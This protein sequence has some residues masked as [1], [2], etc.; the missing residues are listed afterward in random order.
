SEVIAIL[1]VLGLILAFVT[2]VG[3]GIWL[4]LAYLFRRQQPA[5]SAAKPVESDAC[6]RCLTAFRFGDATCPVCDW[7]QALPLGER[8]LSAVLAMRRQLYL[9]RQLGLVG[10][11][12]FRRLVGSLDTAATPVNAAIAE[13]VNDAVET[14]L[15]EAL[16][17][18]AGEAAQRAESPVAEAEVL[19]AEL[20]DAESTESIRESREAANLPSDSAVH[21]ASSVRY[22]SSPRPA[23][24]KLL[25][26]FLE[27]KNIR[28]GELVGGMLIVCCSIALVI[29]FWS[30]I[31]ERPLLKFCVF[32]GVSAAIFA[33]GLYTDRRWKLHTTSRGLL[34][35]AILLAP[36]NFLAIAAFTA[37]S[38]P[39]DVLSLAGEGASLVLF[40]ALCYLAAR[41]LVSDGKWLLAAGVMWPSLMQLLT[42]RYAG[43]D[44]STPVLY[45]LAVGP[46]ASYVGSI[47]LAI[48]G[49]L[50]ENWRLSERGSKENAM[51][52][53]TSPDDDAD[54]AT[55]SPRSSVLHP[56]SSPLPAAT[57]NRLF[58]L[59]GIV[60]FAT[61]LPLGLLLFE[62]QA[63]VPTLES[64]APLT[65][66]LG[67]PSLA[68]GMLF[69]RRVR[70]PDLVREQ[71][72]G[73]GAGVLGAA[74]ML[75]GLP[76]AWPNPQTLLAASLIDA[77][78]FLLVAVWF[79]TP[80]AHVLA[81]VC[82]M[83]AT[84][85]SYH[86]L[87]G[88]VAWAA[89]QD[90]P[91]AAAMLSAMSGNVLAPLVAA[92]LALAYVLRRGGRSADALWWT[93]SAGAVA[94]VSLAL[95]T[96]FGFARP[97]DPHDVTWT[98]FFF[99][100]LLATASFRIARQ[101]I[102]WSATVL[103]L[104]AIVQGVVYRYADAWD[105]AAPW[106]TAFLLH[107]TLASAL[108]VAARRGAAGR[109]LG[110]GGETSLER[111]DRPKNDVPEV[112]SRA[113]CPT[114]W[115]V[116]AV[117]TSIIAA[118]LLVVPFWN[119]DWLPLAWQ[120]AWL[121]AVWLALAVV[122]VRPGWFA[123]F[124]A[125]LMLA[126]F[127]GATH[128]LASREWY[129]AAALP[130]LDPWFLQAQGVGL[131]GYCLGWTALRIVVQRRAGDTATAAEVSSS[132]AS[133][134]P[135]RCRTLLEP[136][137][138]A[139]DRLSEAGVLALVLALSAYAVAPL[140]AQE[141]APLDR[142]G[143]ATRVAPSVEQFALTWL[144]LEHARGDGAWA[145][146]GAAMLAIAA[147]LWEGRV[148]WRG[149]G[150]LLLG[151]AACALAA[152]AWAGSVSAASALRWFLAG[153]VAVASVPLWM[154][155]AV[156]ERL[157][158]IGIDLRD[159]MAEGGSRIVG[160]PTQEAT[161]S[162]PPIVRPHPSV[163][164]RGFGLTARSV[165]ALFVGLFVGCHLAMV[166]YVGVAVV[167][168][169]GVPVELLTL[170][171]AFAILAFVAALLAVLVRLA[172]GEEEGS[173]MGDYGSSGSVD[174]RAE[175]AVA[176]PPASAILNPRHFPVLALLLGVGPLF[177]TYAFLVASALRQHPL[178][179]P[180][181]DAW[182]RTI[183][184]SVSYGLPLAVFAATLVGHAIR[185]RSSRIAFAAAI[186]TNLIA[187]VVYLLELAKLGRPLDGRAWVEVTQ[188]NAIVSAVAAIAWTAAL[189]WHRGRR[190]VARGESAAGFAV[191]CPR[192]LTTL[193]LL[194]A[195]L[196]ML[197]MIPAVVGLTIEPRV[198]PW[199]AAT[200]GPIGWAAAALA[201][202]ALGI[203]ATWA[204]SPD[205]RRAAG[206]R[207]VGPLAAAIV[208]FA[209]L[210]FAHYDGGVAWL[211][212]H[213]L[214]AGVVAASWLLPTVGHIAIVKASDR[215]ASDDVFPV[216]PR[217]APLIGWASL[218]ATA[219]VVLALRAHDVDPASPW[220]TLA[221]L[222]STA[223][224]C[225][226][227]AWIGAQREFLWVAGVLAPL[228]ASIWWI[229][230]R[231]WTL[232]QSHVA[233]PTVRSF[234]F[235]HVNVIAVAVAAL[236]SCFVERRRMK[237]WAVKAA[238]P[239]VGF[240][241]FASW[242]C[243]GTML[244]MTV[245]GIAYDLDLRPV[246]AGR[247]LAIAAL[248][249]TVVAAL[250]CVWDAATR[251][252][253][254]RLWW[255][256]L[257]LMLA[258][259]D[260]RNLYGEAF[261]VTLCVLL[262]AYALV[263]SLV[264]NRRVVFGTIATAWGVP[265]GDLTRAGMKDGR[266]RAERMA[267]DVDVAASTSLGDAWMIAANSVLAV[268]ATALAFWIDAHFEDVFRRT[269]AATGVLACALSL[270]LLVGGV[271]RAVLQC[272]SLAFG[273]LFAVALGWAWL[274]LPIEAA[275]L[276][277]T[278][279]A[280]V[281]LA[282]TIPLYALLLARVM[283][284][285]SG[286]PHSARRT[287][288]AITVVASV[289]LL[290][291]LA[292]EVDYFARVA[293]VPLRWPAVVAVLAVL[294]ML[295]LASLAAAVLPG[296]DPLELGERGRMSYVYAAEALL[297]LAFLHVRLTMPWLFA[298]WFMQFWPL[299]VVSVA[300]LGVGFAELCR[301]RQ[302]RVLSQP[303]ENT[304]AILP[305]LPTIGFWVLPSQV[306]YS[307]LLLSVAALYSALSLLRKSF[308][309][310]VLGAVVA[311][312]SL[313]YW[314]YATQ[315]VAIYE[316]P[317]LW[318]IP[319]ALC[320]LAAAYLN[321]SRLSDDRMT[322]VRYLS[323][324]VVY[325]SSTADIFINGV[326][327]A[328]WLPVAL[329]GLSLLGIFAGILLRVRAFLYLGTTF[330]MVALFTVIWHAAVELDRTWI[331][332]VT[333][334]VT[335]MLIIALFGLFE[336]RRDDMLR[337]VERIKDWKA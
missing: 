224:W 164:S 192:L 268:V 37:E 60:T 214:L 81:G 86:V 94:V 122:D 328:P 315:G 306:N 271:L 40:T 215:P 32:N 78:A 305:L 72:A 196:W 151:A 34:I 43:A 109:S 111:P 165:F 115:S 141:L 204:L 272:G 31:A 152:T 19:D 71:T 287:V 92:Y 220:W 105:I 290:C 116:S 173:R 184:W 3:H 199:V 24:G 178:C 16:A 20:I 289:V 129:Q 139:F 168:K 259:L 95:L 285:P 21:P 238:L 169:S 106:S 234:D 134:W 275:A 208:A 90:S 180:E 138:P 121:S 35:V 302:I 96:I 51:P 260:A 262:S 144:P 179:G 25:S 325:A 321:R 41:V 118:V 230:V 316:H 292:I 104:V 42:R 217:L 265:V 53:P 98:Y 280:A 83:A 11:E 54:A 334:I 245:A 142:P 251:F 101:W 127:F 313:W 55:V 6:P 133:L 221:A 48:R 29:S 317:Q 267:A 298:G 27:E 162:R 176:Q 310:G 300:F 288:G 276:H 128:V 190:A 332:W 284:E 158:R 291:V 307:L 333:G 246:H 23:L 266:S 163:L 335:G 281:A 136:A 39:T 297:A 103:L 182:F 107:A 331:W 303:L 314:L 233:G 225:V 248:C 242:G 79:A 75:A 17:P 50:P 69:W 318:L 263:S 210:V 110:E 201:V 237:P 198:W 5:T 47:A 194:A 269:I 171:Q 166:A 59:L 130:W 65:A 236:V 296:R 135:N 87:S 119:A 76:L 157:R 167:A 223:L 205:E 295:S 185:E 30:E 9:Y 150:L 226:Y 61:L 154:R 80:Q 93:V 195:A 200:G 282:A 38:P 330:L 8:R 279:V 181:P 148:R 216:S 49:Q 74:V 73:I 219:A 207:I 12:T 322:A 188:V 82:L 147:G 286:W 89:G 274:P 304:A 77:A 244:L 211:A 299:V 329:A 193:V 124:Q 159:R 187:T 283:P 203:W 63:V 46:L 131:A 18:R 149:F 15:R 22:P 206:E 258:Y 66:V 293:E 156:A 326:G 26:A 229:D 309:F 102:P 186:L 99:A 52:A 264:W 312:G 137:W 197:P 336:K 209:A 189:R 191:G 85:V 261:D 257:L 28:W 114:I 301:R 161:N 62:T 249:G 10:E 123:A 256:G 132:T 277:R 108:Y 112:A 235:V 278:V 222:I 33:A 255:V 44:V 70:D 155:A 308:W 45:A 13:A 177:I 145:L 14:G 4:L 58:I 84:L 56:Q 146:L 253:V 183:G 231:P 202:A 91:L 239:P 241:R 232:W 337:L 64:I 212:Y 252:M 247:W 7:P 160:E 97:G 273:A 240:H 243:L 254:V 126:P 270:A 143:L 36:L 67:L 327:E 174:P 88:N 170:L 120:L 213:A 228:A 323:A 68:M 294:A 2:V 153:F 1:V 324:I 311:N 125:S 113:T 172:S 175:D 117:A 140:V 218:F 227:L 100:A 250:S 57:A 320:V 319:P